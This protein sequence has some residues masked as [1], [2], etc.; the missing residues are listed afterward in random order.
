[1]GN[2]P[3]YKN[4]IDYKA[5]EQTYTGWLSDIEKTRTKGRSQTTARLANSGMKSGTPQWES[6]LQK[7]ED[8]YQ[9]AKADVYQSSTYQT[10][11]KQ[12]VKVQRRDDYKTALTEAGL[13][14]NIDYSKSYDFSDGYTIRSPITPEK[15]KQGSDIYK[16]FY[17]QEGIGGNF[18]RLVR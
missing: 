2:S 9:A 5:L 3:S 13:D 14:T 11:Q 1:M 15:I 12:K 6:A 16:Q 7:V 8:E 18:N 17:I 4:S 10:V